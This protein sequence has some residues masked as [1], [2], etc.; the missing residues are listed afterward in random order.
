MNIGKISSEGM[1]NLMSTVR[2]TS[3][4]PEDVIMFLLENPKMSLEEAKCY[5]LQE[6]K[7]KKLNNFG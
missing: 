4:P 2:A 7:E 5:G 6:E 1:D 3:T